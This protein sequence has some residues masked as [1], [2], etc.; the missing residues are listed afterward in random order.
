[1]LVGPGHVDD[2]SLGGVVS[3]HG[4]VT[5]QAGNGGDINDT[6]ALLVDHCRQEGLADKVGSLDIDGKDPVPIFFAGFVKF[7]MDHNSGIVDE[8]VDG[9][10]PVENRLLSLF[11]VSGIADIGLNKNNPGWGIFLAELVCYGCPLLGI[12]ADQNGIPIMLQENFGGGQSNSGGATGNNNCLHFLICPF[13]NLSMIDYA[14]F[15][16]AW[17]LTAELFIIKLISKGSE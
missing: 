7:A 5:R 11:N 16:C 6:A 12:T 14:T 3:D 10:E 4:P 9:R 13:H 2:G 15:G 8:G 1:M 17:L